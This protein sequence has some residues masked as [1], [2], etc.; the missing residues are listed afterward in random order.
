LPAGDF[1]ALVGL[2]KPSF[3]QWRKRLG[4]HVSHAGSR[5]AA[6]VPVQ[7]VATDD[8]HAPRHPQPVSEGLPWLEIAAGELVCRV[9]TDVDESTL[10]RLVRVLR[11][12]ATR[13]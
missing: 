9:P 8:S 2:S 4:R 7:V 13:C 5:G 1:A 6:F 12:E 11:E 10:R 3:F